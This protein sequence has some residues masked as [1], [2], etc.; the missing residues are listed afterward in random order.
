MEVCLQSGGGGPLSLTTLD[1][2]RHQLIEFRECRRQKVPPPSSFSL[3]SLTL[4]RICFYLPPFPLSSFP[5]I[6]VSAVEAALVFFCQTD[7]C[8]YKYK[9][10]SQQKRSSFAPPPL[11]CVMRSDAASFSSAVQIVISPSSRRWRKT[12]STPLASAVIFGP[13][14][15]KRSRHLVSAKLNLSRHVA[16]Q[17]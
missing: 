14:G 5:A 13:K 6:H 1:F 7:V 17:L 2:S 4:I 8:A 12:H 16:R 3:S 11:L 15:E 9:I 10:S